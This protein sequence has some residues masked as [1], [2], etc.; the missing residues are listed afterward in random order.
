MMAPASSS[1]RWPAR[2]AYVAAAIFTL[3]SGGTNLIYGWQKG[4]DL[5]GS[6]VWAGVSLGVAIIFALSWPATIKSLEARRWSAAAMSIVALLLAGSYS[7]T[8]ALGVGVRRPCQRRCN[9]DS[10]DGGAQQGPERLRRRQGRARCPSRGEACRRTAIADR[11]C[12]GGAGEAA[13]GALGCGSRGIAQSHTARAAA[14]RVRI[15][16]R[17]NGDVLPQVGWRTG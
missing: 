14:L 2:A 13:G 5:A 11:G 6:V 1:S 4:A 12:Q 15:H 16:Q 17:L 8:A 7:V 3:A 10:D 9:R